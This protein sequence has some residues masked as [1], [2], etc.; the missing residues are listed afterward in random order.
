MSETSACDS[1]VVECEIMNEPDFKEADHSIFDVLDWIRARPAIFLD[2][3]RSLKRLRSFLIGYEC[4]LGRC[5]LALRQHEVFQ[6]FNDWV[7]KKLDFTESTSGWCNMILERTGS[8]EQ[9]YHRFF[10]LLD[11]FRQEEGIV[12]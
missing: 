1:R 7:A 2:G 9:A 12:K 5:H 10:Q 3:D 6:G 4:G 8:D 11:Q